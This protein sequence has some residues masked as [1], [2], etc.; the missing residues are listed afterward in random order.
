MDDQGCR[1]EQLGYMDKI[2]EL[3][4]N[5]IPDDESA[6][7]IDVLNICGENLESLKISNLILECP[8]LLWSDTAA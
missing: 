4:L 8:Y 3:H 6:Y 5:T 2:T 7:F 1:Y